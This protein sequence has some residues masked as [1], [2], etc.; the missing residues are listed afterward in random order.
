MDFSALARDLL[1]NAPAHLREWLPDGKKTGN[2]YVCGD[3]S[4][5]SGTSLSINLR[6]GKW[7][8]FAT[9]D[10]GGDLISLYAAIH[11][12]DQGEAY[13]R[14]GGRESH[15]N[16]R[17]A[18]APKPAP[19]PDR[20]VV[21]PV[22]DAAGIPDFKHPK[23]G[24]PS[25]TWRYAD[26]ADQLLGFVVRY[27]PPGERKQIV[28]WTWDGK[29][30]GMGQWNE[31]RPLYGLDLLNNDRP[32]LLVEGEKAAVAARKFCG[33][34]YNVLTW[35]GGS[36]A[37]RKV[38]WSPLHGRKVLLWP[39]ADAAGDK[40]MLDIGHTILK[41]A[42]PEIKIIDVSGMPDKWDAAD[43]GFDWAAFREWASK[44]VRV[45]TAPVTGEV[46]ADKPKPKKTA[47]FDEELLIFTTTPMKTAQLFQS[48]LPDNGRIIFWRG[49]F[50]SW[51][52]YRYVVREKIYIQQALYSFMSTCYTWKVNQRT[53][54]HEVVMFSPKRSSVEDV[55]HALRAVTFHDLPDGQSWIDPIS[56]DPSAGEIIAFKNGFLHWPTRTLYPSSPRMFVTSALDFD[57]DQNAAAPEDWLD[58]L[59][60]IWPDDPESIR[61][62]AEMFG[63]LL[64]DDTSQQKMFMMVGPPR[65][66]KGTI[67]RILESLVGYTNRV[68]PSLTS[69]GAHFGLQP[70]IGKR[71]AMISDARLSGKADQ[72]PIVENLLR[73]SGEDSLS[74]D[75][76]NIDAWTG[77]LP[78]RFVM[79]TNELPQ[80]S[81]AS[82]A[83]ANRFILFKFENSFLG[84]ED[85]GLTSRLLRDL[86]GIVVWALD[87]LVRVVERGYLSIPSSAQELVDDLI[88][89]TSPIRTFVLEK[90]VI[91]DGYL[92][93]RD[94]LY[95]VWR[96][97][98]AE[99]GRDH[100][101]SKV[102]F[103]RQLSAAFPSI[104]RA[105]PRTAGTRLNM[106]SGARIL[107]S[108]EMQDELV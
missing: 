26:Q 104:K 83:L 106:Y 32:V 100:P 4:G 80:F 45:L 9:G 69:L 25:S 62:L 49:S 103:G 1:S 51:D 35:S 66:G 23:F 41:G 75:R 90:C 47:E 52:G 74:I 15:Q 16:P 56:S 98:C 88:D 7:S 21:I 22:P 99:N 81:D 89:S 3:L 92:C 55:E 101:G 24:A 102:T 94:E 82:S 93:D 85:P 37:I 36:Q 14:L 77:K 60:A 50:Y 108:Y 34:V 31:P 40:C 46:P 6:T 68:S 18:P 44:R 30:W 59:D 33:H 79:A 42:C 87:G 19:V 84:R 53:G 2:E 95:K 76:K 57:Y 64:T 86:P 96:A 20:I 10:A 5:A 27:D 73:I 91:G 70:L 107:A 8:D 17:P 43:A 78:T 11:R 72:Q 39:D 67:L 12:I 13:R 29:R 28:P 105:Q 97:W 58:F 38:D 61:A 65:S 63:Y 54:D 48:R 71:L